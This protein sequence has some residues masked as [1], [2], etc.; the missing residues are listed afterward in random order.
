MDSAAQTVAKGAEQDKTMEVDSWKHLFLA[1]GFGEEAAKQYSDLFVKH[2]IDLSMLADLA[3]PVLESMGIWKAGH[4]IRIL[5]MQRLIYSA[6][7]GQVIPDETDKRTSAD[8]FIFSRKT[9]PPPIE[10]KPV[11]EKEMKRSGSSSIVPSAQQKTPARSGSHT[12]KHSNVLAPGSVVEISGDTSDDSYDSDPEEVVII[13]RSSVGQ[14]QAH[15]INMT[16]SSETSAAA[17]TTSAAIP[18]RSKP[19]G[20]TVNDEMSGSWDNHAGAVGSTP[21]VGSFMHY[22]RNPMSSSMTDMEGSYGPNNGM[23]SSADFSGTPP[24]NA[25]ANVARNPGSR[26]ASLAASPGGAGQNG[27]TLKY[28][29][30]DDVVKHRLRVA[31]TDLTVSKFSGLVRQAHK[32]PSDDFAIFSYDN[33]DSKLRIVK[34]SSPMREDETYYVIEN[35]KLDKIYKKIEDKV[36]KNATMSMADNKGRSV[37]TS[38]NNPMKVDFIPETEILMNQMG[39]IGLCMAPGRKKKKAHH[40]WDRDLDKDLDRI[41]KT[42]NCDVFVSLIRTSE[43]I[44][45]KIPNLFEEVEKRGMESIHF[46]I[47][48]KWIPNSMDGL[49]ALVDALIQRLKEGKTIII[50]CNGGKGRSA[51]VAVAILIGLGKKVQNSIEVVRKARSGTIR[52]PLQIMYVKRFKKAWK[53]FQKKRLNKA[54]GKDSDSDTDLTDDSDDDD[55]SADEEAFKHDDGDDTSGAEG[56]QKSLKRKK[57]EEERRLKEAKKQAE[58]E[59]EEAKKKEKEAKKEEER[60]K[61]EAKKEEEKRRKEEKQAKKEEEKQRKLDDPGKPEEKDK[62][63]QDEKHS[64]A[65]DKSG[66]PKAA[67]ERR[68]TDSIDGN[69]TGSGAEQGREKKTFVK[70]AKDEGKP[71]KSPL[72]VDVEAAASNPGSPSPT[73]PEAPTTPSR[74]RRKLLEEAAAAAAAPSDASESS[75]AP[76]VESPP[77]AAPKEASAQ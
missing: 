24:L 38:D 28:F 50:H 11:E 9:F 1:A 41:Q 55:I 44:A 8:K 15:R 5:R 58:R 13:R 66:T 65:D 23:D 12:A 67:K 31:S 69:D 7:Q 25:S 6:Q 49:I 71:T 2:E 34:E 46:P 35:S 62:K 27:A 54:G 17:H 20:I 51:T 39:R 19:V 40:D 21:P 30:N 74:S 10:S 37:W 63:S 77:A 42:F 64:K 72:K 32:L 4:R 52:N 33:N 73:E 75:A 26:S 14:N 45:L 59:K 56:D 60:R 18:I 68:T 48:D 22:A 43:M 3:H 61:E 57:Q 16:S 76:V 47:K 70:K 29:L 53:A 36:K